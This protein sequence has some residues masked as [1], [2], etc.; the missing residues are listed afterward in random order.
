MDTV[1]FFPIGFF[2]KDF[3]VLPIVSPFKII[4]ISPVGGLLSPAP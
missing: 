3:S 2:F 4:F 1:Y